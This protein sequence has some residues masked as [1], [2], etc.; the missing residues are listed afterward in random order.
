MS[1]LSD[2]NI[3]C[4]LTLLLAQQRSSKLK[5]VMGTTLMYFNLPLDLVLFIDA[6]LEERAMRR[7]SRL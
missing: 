2:G 6:T 4:N 7:V 5:Y 3:A 1:K